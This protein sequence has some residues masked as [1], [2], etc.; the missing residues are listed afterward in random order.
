MV[1]S[2]RNPALSF[3]KRFRTLYLSYIVE[4][5][6]D[7]TWPTLGAGVVANVLNCDIVVSE[8]E[9]QSCYY[10]RIRTNALKKG[11]NSLIS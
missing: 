10:V 3:F 5:L 6:E 2:G 7:V 11:L 1:T 9:L 8:F 4:I